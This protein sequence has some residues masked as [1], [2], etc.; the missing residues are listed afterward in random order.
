M[1][2]M[3]PPGVHFPTAY[4]EMAAMPL[5]VVVAPYGQG[6]MQD[7]VAA[8]GMTAT[9]LQPGFGLPPQHM[10]QHMQQQQPAEQLTPEQQ[11]KVA[12]DKE[13]ALKLLD[14]LDYECTVRLA[15]ML[16]Q[17]GLFNPPALQGMMCGMHMLSGL[18][19]SA[20]GAPQPP[21]VFAPMGAPAVA[22]P[23]SGSVPAAKPAERP[24]E[25]SLASAALG[26]RSAHMGGKASPSTSRLRQ[27]QDGSTVAPR[28]K[29]QQREAAPPAVQMTPQLAR[30][31][32][33][34]SGQPRQQK[35]PPDAATAAPHGHKVEQHK[36]GGRASAASAASAREAPSPELATP[37][38]PESG[39]GDGCC[40]EDQEDAQGGDQDAMATTLILRNLPS[41][42]DQQSCQAW[43][44]KAYKGHYDFL[45][46]FPAKKTSRLNNCSYA[47]VNF[48]TAKH[49][50]Q[51]RDDF[52]LHRFSQDGADGAA[53]HQ[54]PLSVAVA[55][56]QGF[57]G[58]YIRYHHL[59]AETGSTTLCKPFFC[60]GAIE[61]LSKEDVAAAK[62][63]A[64]SLL[65][66]E[67][68][69]LVVRNLPPSIESQELARTW[70]DSAGC[71]GKYNFFLYI[72][73]KKRKADGGAARGGVGHG[74]AYAFVNFK[75]PE[76]AKACID[77][78]DGTHAGVTGESVDAADGSGAV[79]ALSVVVARI[80]GWQECWDHFRGIKDSG[81]LEP[82]VDSARARRSS[83]CKPGLQ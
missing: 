48:S 15:R 5:G 8:Q 57:A 78:L 37:D 30:E 36:A 33:S 70:L 40:A 75:T 82:W 43:V 42:F 44:D 49:A 61:G 77:S 2:P 72:P 19:P 11:K 58:N 3:A 76:S 46:W 14:S 68:T 65:H 69:T 21:G 31:A 80:Q 52:H 13:V 66:G 35:E 60:T 9:I 26:G 50:R 29:E 51:F 4:Q 1:M 24:V 73:P 27:Q 55:K 25:I 12:Y 53:K 7:F 45:L 71:E 18:L 32:S 22:A 28:G 54:W 38:S 20:V 67:T 59:L 81:R 63:H 62:K 41:D 6:M 74:L 34:S 16:H 17:R 39:E 83:P 79:P 10:L 47:F 64:A 23:P 56:V